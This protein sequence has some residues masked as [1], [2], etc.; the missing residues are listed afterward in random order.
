[1]GFINIYPSPLLAYTLFW[2]SNQQL[3]QFATLSTTV[4]FPPGYEAAIVPN[5]SIRMAP[6]WRSAM[7]SAEV[8]EQA[9]EFLAAIKR[10]NIRPE[11][12]EYDPELVTRTNATYNIFRGSSR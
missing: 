5:L 4:S 12:A 10:T 11:V 2:T 6:Y 9:R 8:K 7:V 1:M 3:G